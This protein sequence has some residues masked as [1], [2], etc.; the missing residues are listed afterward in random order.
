MHSSV[1]I[2]RECAPPEPLWETASV[3][4]AIF[5]ERIGR[6]IQLLYARA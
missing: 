6:P 1:V 3:M 5:R 2:G 4:V